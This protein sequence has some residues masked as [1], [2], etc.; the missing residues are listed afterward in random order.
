MIYFVQ[1]VG[2]GPIKIGNSRDPHKRHHGIKSLFPYGVEIITTMEGGRLG[3]G[4]L[5]QCFAPV[6]TAQE[7][8]A[9]CPAVWEFLLDVIKNGRPAWMPEEVKLNSEELKGICIRE[10]G[11]LEVAARRMGYGNHRWPF[12]QVT[13]LGYGLQIRVEFALAVDAGCVPDYIMA[14]HGEAAPVFA[15]AAE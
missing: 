2:G 3:E 8:V 14:L 15:E 6:A 5:H 12:S 7:W 4:F 10:Y 13:T 1:P 11:S 9:A